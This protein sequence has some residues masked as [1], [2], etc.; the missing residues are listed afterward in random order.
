MCNPLHMLERR[1]FEMLDTIDINGESTIIWFAADVGENERSI[2][3][4]KLKTGGID[5]GTKG[6]KSVKKPKKQISEK[7][8]Q[9]AEQK[10]R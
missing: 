4:K 5:M 10:K 8:A 2:P 6:R 9:K 7:K 1:N 3:D